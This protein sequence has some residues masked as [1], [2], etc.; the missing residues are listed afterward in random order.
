MTAHDSPDRDEVAH[1]IRSG[2]TALGIELGST[3]IKAALIGPTHR[4]IAT[5]AHAWSNQF[6]DGLWTYDLTSV[7]AGLQSCYAQLA[8]NVHQDYGV[9]LNTVG[10]LGVS[11]MMHGYLAFDDDGELLAP[12]RT[13]RNTNTD[14]ASRDLSDLFDQNIPHRWSIAHLYQAVLDDEEHLPRLGHLTTLAGYVHNRLTGENVLGVGD[15]SGM[16]PIDVQT[17]TYDTTLVARFDELIAD[18]GYPWTLAEVLPAVLPA[19]VAAGQLTTGGAL[20]LDPTAQLQTGVSLCPPEGDAGTGMVATNSITPGTGNVSAGTSIFAMVVLDRE[21]RA[22]HPEIDLVTTPEGNPVGMVHC[23][24]GTSELDA[25]VS[26]FGEV[27]TAFGATQK[28][29]RLFEQLYRIGL[30]GE[31][32]AGGLVAYNFVSGEPVVGVEHG[33]PLLLRQPGSRFT[34]ANLV[35]AQLN[36]TLGALRVGMDVLTT[37]GIRPHRLYA[38]GGFFTTRDVGQRM[39]AAALDTPVAVTDTASEGGAWGMALL[40]AYRAER[41]DGLTLS[42]YLSENIFDDDS[43]ETLVADPSEVAGFAAYM[44][45]Y[46]TG[47]PI[48]RQA[49]ELLTAPPG[50]I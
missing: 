36:A 22:R 1:S 42:R 24:N 43:F 33:L 17:G 37:E 15:A 16:F 5:G 25:W 39:L 28:T 7:V 35:R 9:E 10:S 20:L 4:P 44:S 31:P 2:H 29:D 30:S 32:D 23:N 48:E 14:A 11:A 12:F 41:S 49:A 38:H 19:G 47:L 40:A 26:L 45:S 18:R 8:D 27:T 3:R 21:L 13:W 46:R 34:L 50:S 6:I